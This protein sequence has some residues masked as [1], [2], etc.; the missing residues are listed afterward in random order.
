M[1][2]FTVSV[3]P[4]LHM[5]QSQCLYYHLI[6]KKM[7]NHDAATAGHFGADKTLERLHQDTFWINMAKDVAEYSRQCIKCQK[8]KLNMPQRA[9]PQNIPIGQPRQMVAVHILQAPLSTNNNRYLFVIQ[10]YVFQYIG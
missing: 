7:R 6:S 1:V 10:D 8:K 5:T 9:P 4:I 2:H 3:D